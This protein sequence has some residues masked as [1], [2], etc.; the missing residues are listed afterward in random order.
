[1]KIVIIEDESL[2]AK[3]LV[4][5]IKQIEPGVEVLALLE[6]VD[7]AVHWLTKNEQ[8]DLFFMDIQL[9][10]GVSFEIFEKANISKPV[11][12]TTAYNEYAIRAFKV[13]S[14]D[15]LL[16]PIDNDHLK[17]AIVKYKRNFTQTQGEVANE[18][19]SFVSSF[20]RNDLP[21]YKE[22]FLA[23]YR[24][25]IIPIPA[26]KVSHFL[27]DTIIYLVTIDNEKLVTD[28]NT[29]DEIEEVID[30]K[31]FFRAN[32]QTII[33]VDAVDTYK[34]HD[35]GKIEVHVKCDKNMHID[36]SREKANDFKNWID[37]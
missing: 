18:L 21:K 12:F 19:Q 8:P 20:K 13:N 31:F 4:R 35:T 11:I 30:P 37:S 34:K 10:D 25:G 32:R 33:H 28:Y 36:I 23:H 2:T 22:R 15:Y 7:A 17:A 6:S 24:S 3:N 1:M 26:P 5:S 27:K 9:S 14:V 29:I 16:K